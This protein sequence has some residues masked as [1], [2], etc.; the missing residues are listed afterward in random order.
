MQGD[1]ESPQDKKILIALTYVASSRVWGNEV[2]AYAWVL[3]AKASVGV[4]ILEKRL[5]AEQIKKGKER[6]AELSLLIKDK[7]KP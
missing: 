5:T 4:S 3:L 2:E 6:A 7:G 1:D